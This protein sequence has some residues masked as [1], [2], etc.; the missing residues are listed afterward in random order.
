MSGLRVQNLCRTFCE[1]RT[2]V[3]ALDRLTLE[4]GAG[5]LLGVLGPSGSGKTTL[6]R[7]IAGLEQPSSGDIELDGKS[8]LS[9]KP[10][11][12]SIGMA[13][14]YPALL[15]QINV[16][17]NI[18]LGPRLRGV[19]SSERSARTQEVADLLGIIDL[20]PRRPET[21]S[22]GQQQRV[23]L[24]RALVTGP[25]LLLLDEPLANLDPISRDEL[26]RSVRFI[27]Q[28]LGV[29]TIYVTHDQSEAAAVADRIA[30]VKAGSLEQA[31]TPGDLYTN[32]ENL[33]V[34]QFFGP[35]IPNVIQGEVR[36]NGFHPDGSGH[37][38]P[39]QTRGGGKATCVIRPRA[40][41]AGG[42]L[43]G[44]IEQVQHRGWSIS[45][46]FN[47]AGFSLRADLPCSAGVHPGAQFQFSLD[48]AELFYFD[49]TGR[50]L[51]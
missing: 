47:F 42:P 51:R 41:R 39:L 31:G 19:Q 18:S 46:F 13:F 32:P 2:K 22:G 16:E 4:V 23:S 33:F 14:Q 5:E 9:E 7:L 12:R 28:K 17:E 6:L 15:P 40:I 24:A 25:K 49:E 26:R 44:I 37:V 48:P 38:F 43:E 1:G 36:G 3:T 29:T 34:A 20:L 27:Q 21:L 35:E 11:L 45:T 30:I 10:Q 8:I 50:R